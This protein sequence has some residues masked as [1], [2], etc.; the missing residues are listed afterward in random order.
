MNAELMKMN[1]EKN[2]LQ[3]KFLKLELEYIQQQ[4]SKPERECQLGAQNENSKT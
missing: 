3:Q 1:E 2:S 4:K